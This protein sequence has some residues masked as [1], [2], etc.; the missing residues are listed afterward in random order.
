MTTRKPTLQQHLEAGPRKRVLALDGGGLRGIFSL[1]YLAG[2]EE[3]LRVRHGN[4][5][6]FRLSHYFD[7]IAGTST[8]AIIAAALSLG[9]TVEEIIDHYEAM[10]RD[11]FRKAITRLGVLRARYD[12]QRLVRSLKAVLGADR[13]LG[14]PDIQTGLLVMTKRM[15][16]G[17]PW[18]LANNPAG[19]YFIAG[20]GKDWISN[21]DYPLWK[22]VRASTAAPHYFDPERITIS[23]QPGRKAVIGNFVDGGVSP[24]N[25]PSLQAFMYATLRGY[26]LNWPSGESNLF[27][28]SVGTGRSDPSQSPALIAAADAIKGLLSLMDDSAAL[29]ET[30][31]Q[32]MSASPKAREIDRDIGD[33]SGD[34]LCRE[35]LFTYVRYNIE[36]SRKGIDPLM[37][38]LSATKIRELSAMDEP[39]NLDILK[40]LGELA[41]ARD[42]TGSDFPPGFDLPAA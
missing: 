40:Q 10:G 33:L 1:G 32:W 15:D 39:K 6:A 37:P 30:M 31:M 22:V 42:L 5:P 14:S 18:P 26:G 4:D 7:L 28:V 17:S 13:T 35:P 2:M 16:T 27:I 23:R 11:V 29:V 3:M 8:G 36:L 12:E 24:F 25:N 38:G 20:P 19:K 34:Q 9:L 21:A 41:A